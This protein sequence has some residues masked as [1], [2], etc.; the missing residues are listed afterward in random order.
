MDISS[1]G[2]KRLVDSRGYGKEMPLSLMVSYPSL[3]PLSHPLLGVFNVDTRIVMEQHPTLPVV[4][5]SGIDET[6]KVGPNTYP[7]GGSEDDVLT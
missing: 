3:P 7:S 5:V 6:I 1:Y 4:A 2:I